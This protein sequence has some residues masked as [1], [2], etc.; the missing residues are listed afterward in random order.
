M[1][2]FEGFAVCLESLAKQRPLVVI[3]EDLHWA[4]EATISAVQFIVRRLAQLPVLII[5][6]YREEDA[7]R[8]HPLRRMRRELQEEKILFTLAPTP[9][10]RDDV[11]DLL[12][13]IFG[14]SAGVGG[15]EGEADALRERSAG[16]PLFLNELIQGMREHGSEAA[17]AALPQTAR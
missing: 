12:G 10:G 17:G 8:A 2:L 16:N 9:L 1:R 4:G 13:R 5:A 11:A 3:L 15:K 6:T 14:A 7:P